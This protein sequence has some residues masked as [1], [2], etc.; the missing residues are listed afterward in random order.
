[1]CDWEGRGKEVINISVGSSQALNFKIRSEEAL[2]KHSINWE[3]NFCA[4][5]QAKYK[6]FLTE[7]DKWSIATGN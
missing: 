7:L 2:T 4:E 3:E 1:M 6:L 5:M